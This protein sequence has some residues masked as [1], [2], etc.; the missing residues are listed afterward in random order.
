M[1]EIPQRVFQPVGGEPG[2]GIIRDG[3]AVVVRHIRDCQSVPLQQG[4]QCGTAADKIL[5]F[6]LGGLLPQVVAVEKV[7]HMGKYRGGDIVEQPCHSL[8]GTAGEMPDDEGHAHAV[9]EPG[10]GPGAE[11]QRKTGVL[12]AA[13]HAHIP[14]TDQGRRVQIGPEKRGYLRVI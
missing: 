6:L 7:H 12:A 2:R 14:Q 10:T 11:K 4:Q 1:P 8:P 5:R 9:V 3:V 13:V